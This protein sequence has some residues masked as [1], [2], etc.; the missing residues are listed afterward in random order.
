MS[1][2]R[3]FLTSVILLL[4][5][6]L[7][8]YAQQGE[9]ADF[10]IHVNSDNDAIVA[11]SE[12]DIYYTYGIGLEMAFKTDSLLSLE[13]LFPS[14]KNY[15]FN[16]GIRMEGYTPSNKDVKTDD[17]EEADEI[18]DRPFAG[19][20][21]ATMEA[22]YI[23]ENSTLK[24]GVLLGIM[25]PSSGAGRLQVWFHK[26]ITGGTL[27]DGWKFQ[28]PDQL[29]L[30]FNMAYT[31]EFTPQ[32]KIIS[33]FGSGEVLFGNLYM[34][35]TPSLGF[36]L[37][38]FAP[39]TR[40]VAFGNG[41]LLNAKE[42]ELFFLVKYGVGLNGYNATAQGNLF[43]PKDE[44]ALSATN[45]IDSLLTLGMYFSYDH[46]SVNLNHYFIFGSVVPKSNH[47]YARI[48]FF[49]RF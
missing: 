16:A 24:T 30:N 49:R 29:L 27:V 4:C 15:F 5:S 37:G 32:A 1:I 23:F 7:T 8:C 21:F 26:T 19:L 38:N 10:E 40:S 11:W 18:F 22:N 45:T 46:W 43:G 6:V 36:R 25:G 9:G 33:A 42:S 48:G 28:L 44:F 14:K 47:T 31:H 39:I 2:K 41:T 17:K 34:K 13:N 12:D 35:A 3:F 20:L